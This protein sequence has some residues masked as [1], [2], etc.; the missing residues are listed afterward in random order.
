MILEDLIIE[1]LFDGDGDDEA[2]IVSTT[3]LIYLQITICGPILI[4]H[5][6]SLM[7]ISRVLT[8]HVMM[9]MIEEDM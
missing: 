1:G 6:V 8:F 2:G 5:V 7:L 3:S 4:L 9:T